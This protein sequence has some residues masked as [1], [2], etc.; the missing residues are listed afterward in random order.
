MYDFIPII[1]PQYFRIFAMMI[2]LYY[3]S[4]EFSGHVLSPEP[5]LSPI[6]YGKII[7]QCTNVH[8]FFVLFVPQSQGSIQTYRTGT[9]TVQARVL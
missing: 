5:V 6:I 7:L 3:K 8:M 4:S 2:W 9:S 1:L